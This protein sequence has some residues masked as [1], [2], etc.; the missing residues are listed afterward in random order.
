MD[1]KETLS[2]MAMFVT[3]AIFV[4]FVWWGV[5]AL[6]NAQ[7]E[8][9]EYCPKTYGTGWYFKEDARGPDFCTNDKGEVRY[10]KGWT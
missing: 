3:V 4:A 8:Q 7:K 2:D 1:T 6:N 9:E 5:V 10:P